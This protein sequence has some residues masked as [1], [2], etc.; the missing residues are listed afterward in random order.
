MS[1][2]YRQ[3]GHNLPQL[4][5]SVITPH[6]VVLSFQA[7]KL[8][9]TNLGRYIPPMVDKYSPSLQGPDLLLI[10]ML[11]MKGIQNFFLFYL[12]L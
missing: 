3:E 10:Q 5:G 12:L 11:G 8:L 2:I 7:G 6:K 4:H 9:L 1:Q